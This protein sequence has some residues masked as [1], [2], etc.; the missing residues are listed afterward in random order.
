MVSLVGARENSPFHRCAMGLSSPASRKWGFG[1]RRSPD[2]ATV[3]GEWGD[4]NDVGVA[5]QEQRIGGGAGGGA[6]P[7]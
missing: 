6:P 2:K 1:A 3:S 4:A 5:A 7:A